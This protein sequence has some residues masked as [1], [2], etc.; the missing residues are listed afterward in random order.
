MAASLLW[1]N[2]VP[3]LASDH[4]SVTTDASGKVTIS[5]A[6]ATVNDAQDGYALILS[7]Y[8]MVG[9][10]IVGLCAIISITALIFYIT[11]LATAGDN[12]RLKQSA[13]SGIMFSGIALALFG[14]LPIVL[15]FWLSILN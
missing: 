10:G 12:P 9:Q 7:K 4:I 13:V 11:K 6:G 8:K 5:A 2:P 15:H 3:T 1:L 14:G